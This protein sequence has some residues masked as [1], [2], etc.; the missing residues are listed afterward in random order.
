MTAQRLAPGALLVQTNLTGAVGDIQ[1]DP[2]SP[3]AAWL[4]A[5]SVADVEARVSFPSPTSNL[6]AGAGRQEFRILARQNA[7]GGNNPSVTVELYENGAPVSTLISGQT[8]S[9][10]TGI[11]L[12]GTWDAAS[13]A[14]IS[15]ADVECRVL[16]NRAGG[17]PANRRTVEIGAIEW[18]A[19]YTVA[20]IAGSL[21]A[22]E[23]SDAAA[24]AGD[25]DIAGLL[26]ASESADTTALAGA[27]EVTGILAASE[28]S[29]TAAIAGATANGITGSLA[30]TEVVDTAAI[31]AGIEVAGSLA[32][33]ETFDI[34]A[35]AGTV[36]DGITGTLATVEAPD[37]AVIAGAITIAGILAA[38]EPIDV[39]AITGG[40]IVSGGLAAS[41]AADPTAFTGTVADGITGSLAA[42]EA[43]DA[44]VVAGAVTIA[45]ILSGSEPIDVAA[46]VGTLDIAGTLAAI[47]M[48]DT[49]VLSEPPPVVGNPLA[50]WIYQVDA[51]RQGPVIA[52]GRRQ[53]HTLD[54][55]FDPVKAE[56][57]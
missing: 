16:G 31:E 33:A 32:A 27:I 41:E 35:L 36:A 8:I 20:G 29:D 51:R 10:T 38:S 39:S 49:A 24:I 23:A 19:D 46:F 13:L 6:T 43:V 37:T 12:S 3:D 56:K 14:S 45:G 9:S 50:P 47:E 54:V 11:V 1:D 17:P 57:S 18:N 53:T 25:L 52:E 44:A 22:T 21:T 4:T 5:A 26:T 55:V 28:A 15:G 48:P 7:S 42:T 34:A 40:I 30:A 2:D